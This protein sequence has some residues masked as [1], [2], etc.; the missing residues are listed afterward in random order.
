MCCM[1]YAGMSP[2]TVTD[3]AN[4]HELACSGAKEKLKTSL[5]KTTGRLKNY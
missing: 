3:H 4:T 2:I 5:E 1:R